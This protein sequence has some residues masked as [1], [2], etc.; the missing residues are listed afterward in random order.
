MIKDT[1]KRTSKTTKTVFTSVPVGIELGAT[2]TDVITGFTGVA[3]GLA[4][5][6][7]GAVQVLLT[8][9]ANSYSLELPQVWFDVQR[10][11]RL[12][13]DV[14]VVDSRTNLSFDASITEE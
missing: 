13:V 5:Y 10:C 3:S 11:K 1:F 14:V 12:E 6:I 8:A 9:K 4:V 7:A 2:Y